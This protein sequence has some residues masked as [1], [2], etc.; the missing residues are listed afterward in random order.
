[1]KYFTVVNE[2]NIANKFRFCQEAVDQ[3]DVVL[4]M[5]VYEVD[6]V[7]FSDNARWS[8]TVTFYTVVKSGDRGHWLIVWRGCKSSV[9]SDL[10]RPSQQPRAPCEKHVPTPSYCL[11]SFYFVHAFE[12]D[13]YELCIKRNKNTMRTV[14]IG[15]NRLWRLYYAMVEISKEIPLEEKKSRTSVLYWQSK[16]RS[17]TLFY[18]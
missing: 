8:R 4:Y 9:A 3:Q 15:F 16:V 12:T 14:N 10:T 1:M 7:L 17:V 13:V 11:R 6:T 5:K 18:L 2:E